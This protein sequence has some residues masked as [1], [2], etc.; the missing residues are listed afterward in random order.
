[1]ATKSS[2]KAEKVWA[3]LVKNKLATPAEV[4]KATG[5][6]Y[7]YVY[8][9]MKKIGTPKEVF[10][11]EAKS[12]AKKPLASGGVLKASSGERLNLLNEAIEL[13]GGDRNA[14]YGDPYDNHKLI[15]DI[16]TLITGKELTAYD[17]V[18]VQIATKLSRMKVSRT[19]R[20]HY[21]DLMAYAGIAYECL[22]EEDIS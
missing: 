9:L 4:A 15:A 21:V 11:E 17:I 14:D 5:V 10:E 2:P 3:Y 1:M 7:G 8:K 12:T 16:A 19:K 22:R 13:T 20:D 6:S 18:M